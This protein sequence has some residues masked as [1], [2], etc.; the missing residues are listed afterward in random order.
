MKDA[1]RL[2]ILAG[3]NVKT[4]FTRPED[5]ILQLRELG[6]EG[7]VPVET[8]N[9]GVRDGL[10][11]KFLLGL[12]DHPYIEDANKTKATVNSAQHQSVALR[13][14]RESLVLLKND[15]NTLPL[16]KQIKSIA[17]VGP[18]ADDQTL[19]PY[20]YGPSAVESVTGLRGIKNSLGSNVAVNYAKGCE[21]VDEHWPETE[22]LPEPL[23]AT[24]EA[25]VQEAVAAVKKSE[26]AIVVLG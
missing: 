13:A 10:R 18:N 16:S 21:V 12:F 6:K 20:R 1:V 7:K 11:V 9:C 22:V 23:T 4:N 17:V 5:F 15:K 24:E 26:V 2:S 8:W 19:I 14:A 3:L 25:Q